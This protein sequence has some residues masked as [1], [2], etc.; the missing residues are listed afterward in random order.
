MDKHA[1]MKGHYIMDNTPIHTHEHIKKSILSIE[2]INVC[3]FPFI[4]PS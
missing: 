4:L 2:D 3:I 1:H